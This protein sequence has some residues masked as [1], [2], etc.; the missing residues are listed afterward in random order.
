MICPYCK[1]GDILKANVKINH[2]II[3]ICE[4]CDTVW[5]E[6]ETISSQTG[7][8]FENFAN[9]LNIRALWDE[10]GLI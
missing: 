6:N 3:F 8:A 4:E 9:Q 1:Q 7:R 10:L 5:N 2:Q